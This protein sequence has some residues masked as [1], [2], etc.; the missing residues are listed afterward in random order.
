LGGNPGGEERH[1]MKFHVAPL[2][3]EQSRQIP[4]MSKLLLD[5]AEP[6]L[7]VSG[8]TGLIPIIL[9][10]DRFMGSSLDGFE[11][12]TDVVML[13]DGALKVCQSL[14]LN[15]TKTIDESEL[16]QKYVLLIGP[17]SAHSGE[18]KF[19]GE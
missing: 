6:A 3:D 14:N 17:A 12:H 11:D 8:R 1:K 9:I 19:G 16:P 18:R 13:N 15:V 10:R 2:S 5:L 4:P 7:L